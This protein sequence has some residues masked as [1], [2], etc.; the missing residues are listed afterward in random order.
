MPTPPEHETAADQIVYEDTVET[1]VVPPPVAPP[2]PPPAGYPVSE[3]VVV[4]DA[5]GPRYVT[6]AT[7]E[8]VLVDDGGNEA[9][10]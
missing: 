5:G 2:P 1:A 9:I 7:G 8:R 4:E 10:I 3:Q 6:T